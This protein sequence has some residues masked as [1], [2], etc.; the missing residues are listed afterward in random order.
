M[1]EHTAGRY[2]ELRLVSKRMRALLD[3]HREHVHVCHNAR[4]VRG[5]IPAFLE[6][7]RHLSE[8]RFFDS[9][10]LT[11]DGFRVTEPWKVIDTQSEYVTH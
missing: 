2:C 3:L 1:Y 7:L 5:E 4:V 8:R 10:D 9:L 6:K 11:N